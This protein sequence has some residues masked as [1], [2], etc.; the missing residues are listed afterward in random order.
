MIISKFL[1]HEKDC[2]TFP[3]LI[4]YIYICIFRSL[5]VYLSATLTCSIPSRLGMRI[6]SSFRKCP[7]L[8]KEIVFPQIV[9]WVIKVQLSS[10][11]GFGE[12]YSQESLLK[13]R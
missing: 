12:F 1:V 3:K 2:V 5:A 10:Y 11:P 13:R 4:A 7:L 9:S 6:V 8:L